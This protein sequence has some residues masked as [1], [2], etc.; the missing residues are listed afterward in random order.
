MTRVPSPSGSNPY[1]RRAG[2]ARR[3]RRAATRTLPA[4]RRSRTRARSGCS[5]RARR[6]GTRPACR[7]LAVALEHRDVL[8]VARPLRVPLVV[9][10]D[11]P[12]A[13]RRRRDGDPLVRLVGHPP[14][15]PSRRDRRN[16]SRPDRRGQAAAG[17]APAGAGTCRGAR[18]RGRR[19]RA[20]ASGRARR[21]GRPPRSPTVDHETDAERSRTAATARHAA[22]RRR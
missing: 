6:R 22:R 9:G 4:P 17:P 16:R 14:I 21:T 11:L 19:A 8:H 20:G 5:C 2:A 12:A 7:A 1:G 18:P 3:P 15:E 10:R 13:R